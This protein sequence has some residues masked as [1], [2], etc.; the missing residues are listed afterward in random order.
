M[1][2]PVGKIVNI[3]DHVDN[4]TQW[5]QGKGTHKIIPSEAEKL[6]KAAL[7]KLP[8]EF[9]TEI[10]FRGL[11][12]KSGRYAR[13]DFWLPDIGTLIEYDGEQYH[14]SNEAIQRDELKEAF[15]K[16]HGIKLIRLDK[17][18]YYKLD[19]KIQ[20]IVTGSEISTVL[21]DKIA[22]LKVK[23]NVKSLKK[24]KEQ[25]KKRVEKAFKAK[26]KPKITKKKE[27]KV[28]YLKSRGLG[29]VIPPGMTVEE[30]QEKQANLK[31]LKALDNEYIK[32]NK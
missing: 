2:K 3:A 26:S 23:P 31:R 16:K 30:Y 8:Y 17:R 7:Q 13:F 27:A 14:S 22:P 5:F 11:R 6:V 21:Y 19:S 18:H 20:S 25:Y 1:K 29:L 15:C 28:Q 32:K 9:H 24:K 4:P 12:Y 10:S